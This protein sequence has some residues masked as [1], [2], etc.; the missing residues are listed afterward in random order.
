M[1]API[2][3]AFSSAWA[4]FKAHAGFFIGV[5]ILASIIVGIPYIITVA[6]SAN[7]M[8]AA[9]FIFNIITLIVA[10]IIGVG[11]TT[12]ALSALDN[13]PLSVGMLF[14]NMPRLGSYI[15]A[16]I[17]VGIIVMVGTFLLII[18]GIYLAIRLTFW[19]YFVVDKGM[20]A[21]DAIK[22]SWRMTSG[23][24]F[25][26]FVFGLA[27]LGLAILG[28]IPLG[29]GWLVVMPLVLLAS[30]QLYRLLTRAPAPV[31]PVVAQA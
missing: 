16:T 9:A 4:T 8:G 27:C 12:I 19:P 2:G 7:D 29:L 23:R 13:K 17:L 28:A 6:L 30:A 5:Y 24:F 18:P 20:S 11:M 21:I 15:L 14:S 25:D 31:A 10:S 22:G 26:V 3:P 1:S